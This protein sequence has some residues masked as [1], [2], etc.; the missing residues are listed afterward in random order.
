M[1]I[2]PKNTKIHIFIRTPDA[3]VEQRLQRGLILLK[4]SKLSNEFHRG[5]NVLAGVSSILGV[6]LWFLMEKKMRNVE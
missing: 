3:R 4:K 2:A 6:S 1:I 5:R